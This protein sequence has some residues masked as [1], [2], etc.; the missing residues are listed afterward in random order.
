MKR[1]TSI[2]I[3]ICLIVAAIPTACEK[4]FPGAPAEEDLLDGPMDHLSHTELAQFLRGDQIFN[5]RVFTP[6]TG[7]GPVFVATSCASCH[8]GDG[9]G[10][11][12]NALIRFGQSDSTGNKYLDQ[13]GFQLQNRAIPGYQPE[14]LPDG[15]PF[16]TF[17]GPIVTGLGFLDLV[18]DATIL[19]MEA[20]N[21]SRTD[22]VR[23]RPNYITPPAYVKPRR[24]AIPK[25]GK[26]I[27]RFGFKASVYDLHQQTVVALN[28]DIGITSIFD[29]VDQWSGRE[30]E[31][32]ISA[33]DVHDLVFY[34]QTLKAPIQR[35][36]QHPE[37]LKGAQIFRQIGCDGCHRPTLK[38][39]FSPITP[40][41]EVVF[42]PYTDLLV[43]DLGPEMDDGY[44]E[45]SVKSSEWRTA[46]LWGLGLA[47]ASQGGR[48]YL[49]H[50]GRAR[51]IEEAILLHGGEGNYS[52][53][54]YSA[55][56]S[57]DKARLIRF[58]ESL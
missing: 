3:F 20:E 26:L 47:K 53:T 16:S 41:S 58:L 1:K 7:L 31:P 49:M 28:Q 43:H 44:T 19:Q 57:D 8:A 37:V 32:E 52:R 33:T 13:G 50:D 36:P 18:T 56:P 4:I 15:A 39:G 29:P 54:R 12:F 2:L 22:G 6:E 24:T 27:G 9:K 5:D 46:P 48:Y 55:L 34:L 30:I 40:L 11:P 14:S 42:H 23:G 38:T 17:L 10:H 45:G 51:S 25:D 21:K 35:E